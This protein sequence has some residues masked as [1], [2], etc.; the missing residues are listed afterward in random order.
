MTSARELDTSRHSRIAKG[1][2]QPGLSH[3]IPEAGVGTEGPARMRHRGSWKDE[4]FHA[5]IAGCKLLHLTRTQEAW[6]AGRVA[7][8][9]QVAV[10]IP[11]RPGGMSAA[12]GRSAAEGAEREREGRSHDKGAGQTRR[13]GAG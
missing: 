11:Q 4:A 12:G 7:P 1:P 8:Q 2:G 3:C 6:R 5:R 9:E 13:A 10:P